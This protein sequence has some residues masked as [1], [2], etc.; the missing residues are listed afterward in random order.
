MKF[1]WYLEWPAEIR[2]KTLSFVKNNKD[3]RLISINAL[4]YAGIIITYVA[5][6]HFFLHNPRVN[7]PHPVALLTADNTTAESWIVKACMN[8]AIGRAL[9]RVQCALMINNPV[10]LN[11]AHISSEDNIVADEIS[12]INRASNADSYF[13]SLT[14]RFPELAGCRRF[15]PSSELISMI[16]AAICQQSFADPVTASRRLLSDLGRTTS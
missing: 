8:S 2:E 6:T 12:R 3:G 14:Q 1:W 4:E 9:G 13:R 11:S 16:M 15:H 5:S 10:G 7:D